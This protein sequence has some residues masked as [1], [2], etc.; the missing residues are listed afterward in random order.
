MSLIQNNGLPVAAGALVTTPVVM[1]KASLPRQVFRLP[2]PVLDLETAEIAS[3]AQSH[4]LPFLAVRTITDG[5]GEEIQP[6]LADIVNTYQGVPLLRL[7][8]ALR[9][10][11]RRVKYCLHLWRRSR[12]AGRNL[13]RALNLIFERLAQ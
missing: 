10:D 12:L 9:T 6:F 5:G 7:L 11:P 4:H 2:F 3:V 8:A 1:T 13:A